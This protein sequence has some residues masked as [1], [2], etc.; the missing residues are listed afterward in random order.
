MDRRERPCRAAIP[1]EYFFFQGPV[2]T[3][4]AEAVLIEK[5]NW[6]I[7]TTNATLISPAASDGG[8]LQS[9]MRHPP[10]IPLK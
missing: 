2:L 3:P 9:C 4:F 1:G 6:N 8:G 5:I 7:A 10:W